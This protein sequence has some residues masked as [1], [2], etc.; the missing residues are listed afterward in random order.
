MFLYRHTPPF[1]FLVTQYLL[2]FCFSIN[3][4]AQDTTY[5]YLDTGYQTWIE[6]TK[7]KAEFFRPGHLKKEGDLFK[8][9][10]F[11]IN[12]NLQMSGFSMNEK[13]DIYEG[14]VSWYFLN[15]TKQ[16]TSNYKAGKK[17]G[18]TTWF[19]FDGSI[20]ASGTYEN[21]RPMDGCFVQEGP[22]GS[23]LYIGRQ[24]IF[25]Y[26]NNKIIGGIT[27]YLNSNQIAI[28]TSID[29]ENEEVNYIYFDQKGEKIGTYTYHMKST[30]Q[31]GIE[32][33]FYIKNNQAV[34]I[35]SIKSFKKGRYDGKMSKYSKEGE[36]IAKG[37]Y[38]AGEPYDGSF[39]SIMGILNYKEGVLDGGSIFYNLESDSKE[40]AR[41][42]YKEG[43]PWE[44][45]F[46]YPDWG[47]NE[48][49]TYKNGK[50]EGKQITFF[51]ER[52]LEKLASYFY[53]SNGMKH[54]EAVKFKRNGEILTKGI[55]KDDQPWSGQFYEDVNWNFKI[56]T[57]KEGKLN[58]P[59]TEYNRNDK[60]IVEKEFKDNE[61]TGWEAYLN[62]Y[63]GKK[64]R[65][66]FKSNDG[67]GR[68]I[69]EGIYYNSGTL[70]T[71]KS[72][73]LIENIE[74]NSETKKPKLIEKFAIKTNVDPNLTTPIQQ[75]K[76]IYFKDD[77]KYILIY[78]N[79]LPYEGVYHDDYEKITYQQG[80]KQG[81]YVHFG[82]YKNTPLIANY[83]ENKIQ[84]KVGFI[85]RATLDTS[86]CV[87]RDDVPY[88]GVYKRNNTIVPYKNGKKNGL[89]IEPLIYFG[90]S[91]FMPPV[92]KT[93]TVYIEDFREGPIVYYDENENKLDEA[94]FKDDA[95][96]NGNFY[97]F[98]E[99]EKLTYTQGKL[100]RHIYTNR[101]YIF[102]L[103]YE[104][105]HLIPAD[106][107][108]GEKELLQ[109][110]YK[111]DQPYEGIFFEQ[112][113]NSESHYSEKDYT[114]TN[115]KG[116]K[117][118]GLKKYFSGFRKKLI[119]AENFKHGK[120]IS[121]TIFNV[122][123]RGQTEFSVTYQ[124]GLPYSGTVVSHPNELY[125][126]S[127]YQNGKKTG[128][129]YYLDIG[130]NG[131]VIDSLYF[132]NGNPIKGFHLEECFS[133]FHKHQYKDGQI[134]ESRI[135]NY[136]VPHYSSILDSETGKQ[137]PWEVSS[138][139]KNLPVEIIK[140]S[141][142]GFKVKFTDKS[143]QKADQAVMI[144]DDKTKTSGTL[145]YS[146][147]SIPLGYFK[148]S[149]G[150][151]TDFNFEEIFQKLR[152]DEHGQI[153]T[154]DS[155]NHLIYDFYPKYELSSP[156]SYKDFFGGRKLFTS[157]GTIYGFFKGT[158]ETICSFELKD[159]QIYSG[160]FIESNNDG[161]FEINVYKD[162]KKI[163]EENDHSLQTL[164]KRLKEL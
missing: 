69:I 26:K 116:G 163:I 86:Y 106:F 159:E 61:P 78:Q 126:I 131:Q 55:Y 22:S 3:M 27:T 15:G 153:H 99:D 88:E 4:I 56:S 113:P 123:F 60:F 58:G 144:F 52:S 114:L 35:I 128:F 17:N 120:L 43:L 37:V 90:S 130:K 110:L 115:F 161:S 42:T 137:I 24:E 59:V 41:G 143:K 129:E 72:G 119:K 156:P 84:G 62:P 18:M 147:Y 29:L 50:R 51:D 136:L 44:G 71:Y 121:S 25:E 67:Y 75:T 145:N 149:N 11:Y 68:K 102:D 49:H 40:I 97:N 101:K 23:S 100:V 2:F 65:V 33:D 45:V 146:K 38:R 30:Y 80:K 155:M 162:G 158:K 70:K 160:T 93:T 141:Q 14:E 10:D 148:F 46:P 138:V 122:E 133:K 98:H 142:N 87:Y 96:Y 151:I 63:T 164:E 77:I 32:I 95:H 105:D 112:D 1:I 139:T 79:D 83:E 47:K 5:Y 124:D 66:F 6:T 21:N 125:T 103:Q 19:N 13:R 92:V 48:L 36:L 154:R 81:P 85:H 108:N 152:K 9:E 8:V 89:V 28:Q 104:N 134:V 140:Y 54:G 20:K 53:I 135:Y 107:D 118:D 12:G 94:F 39:E 34:R 7:D 57:Y 16:K 157:E 76:R 127:N 82:D 111:N 74:Y 150:K 132:E 73:H 109:G 64:N 117:K 91:N 31:D